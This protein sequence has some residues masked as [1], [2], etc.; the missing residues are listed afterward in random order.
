M[1]TPE[2][3]NGISGRTAV[4]EVFVM[5]KSIESAILKGAT[6]P[7]IYKAVR[8]KGMLTMKEDA[9][10]KAMQRLIPFEEV[11]TL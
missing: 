2:C 5:D 10:L 9:I 8:V 3:V 4:S 1:P 7:E 11:N 6:E